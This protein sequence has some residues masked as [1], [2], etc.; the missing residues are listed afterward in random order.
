[1]NATT[2]KRSRQKA[3]R[4]HTQ[5]PNVVL[6]DTRLSSDARWI[7]ALLKVHDRPGKGEC[8]PGQERLAQLAMWKTKGGSWDRWRVQR[9]LDELEEASL[10][11]RE[12]SGARRSNT[13]RFRPVPD[14][15][16]VITLDSAASA[17][18]RKSQGKTKNKSASSLC[19]SDAQP[20]DQDFLSEDGAPLRNG[21]QQEN[22]VQDE[23]SGQF[24]PHSCALRSSSLRGGGKSSSP[25]ED[26]VD[27]PFESLPSSACEVP[28]ELVEAGVAWAQEPVDW[29]LVRLYQLGGVRIIKQGR[30]LQAVT[31]EDHGVGQSD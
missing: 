22:G 14:E 30:V 13:Y 8:W 12:R 19:A 3:L 16:P 9:A 29:L 21:A 5:L 6:L 24:L 1:M 28:R 15:L 11:W 26:V 7:Y 17:P 25:S 31:Y 10:I 23:V 27:G 2:K 4:G 18:V 20:S